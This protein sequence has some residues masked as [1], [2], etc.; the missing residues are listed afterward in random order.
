MEIV[1]LRMSVLVSTLDNGS[2]K[3]K[4]TLSKLNHFVL[5]I[6]D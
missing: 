1:A 6:Y 5:G 2:P 3:T 4:K